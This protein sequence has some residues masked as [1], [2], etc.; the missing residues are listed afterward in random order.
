MNLKIT[1]GKADFNTSKFGNFKE[2]VMVEFPNC[3]SKTTNKSFKWMP[4]YNQLED[5][6]K[7]L[8]DIEKESWDKKFGLYSKESPT[9]PS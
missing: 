7:A 8:A 3:I 2:V 6:K 5:I 1:K 4:T 9:N